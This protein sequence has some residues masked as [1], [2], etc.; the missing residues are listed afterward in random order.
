MFHRI[1]SYIHVIFLSKSNFVINSYF[2]PSSHF[3]F[4]ELLVCKSSIQMF[5]ISKSIYFLKLFNH[6]R[7]IHSSLSISYSSLISH[8][9]YFYLY[10]FFMFFSRNKINGMI[11]RFFSR[12]F[13]VFYHCFLRTWTHLLAHFEFFSWC[14]FFFDFYWWIID[15]GFFFCRIH[16]V[17]HI[18]N[19]ITSTKFLPKIIVYRL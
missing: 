7:P 18:T 10:F 8:F 12:N 16:T 5:F 6:F 4:H 15:F 13:R 19:F 14:R 9:I 3:G 11:F 1:L 2:A 17:K